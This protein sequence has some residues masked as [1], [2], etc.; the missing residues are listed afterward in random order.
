MQKLFDLVENLAD[1]ELPNFNN[2]RKCHDW[3]N[4]VPQEFQDNWLCFTYREK[5]IIAI[6]AYEFAQNEEWN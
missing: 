3:G 5:Q 6:M 1:I 2:K 4:Y